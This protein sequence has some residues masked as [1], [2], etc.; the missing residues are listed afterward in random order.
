MQTSY[1]TTTYTTPVIRTEIFSPTRVVRYASPSRVVSTTH[2]LDG[3]ISRV[4]EENCEEEVTTTT[5][6]S[7]G[8]ITRSTFSP[9]RTYRTIREPV[10]TVCTSYT[11]DQGDDIREVQPVREVMGENAPTR[12][13]NATEDIQEEKR[14]EHIQEDQA[15]STPLKQTTT[16][17]APTQAPAPTQV[18]P[19]NTTT[20]AQSPVPTYATQPASPSPLPVPL[21]P[22]SYISSYSYVG[23]CGS[24]VRFSTTTTTHY[25]AAPLYSSSTT[26]VSSPLRS[27]VVYRSPSRVVYPT[28]TVVYEQGPRGEISTVYY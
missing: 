16:T 24:P 13:V 7:F 4:F 9:V 22:R 27:S 10:Q 2:H 25:P 3:S 15:P 11:E 18:P 20:K 14:A 21:I 8:P 17:Q 28:S 6:G 23:D 26:Y 19:T 12:T 1:T 5:Y